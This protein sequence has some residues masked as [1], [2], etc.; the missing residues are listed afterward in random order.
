MFA[1][2][3]GLRNKTA[4]ARV[5]TVQRRAS[6][7]MREREVGNQA[8]LRRLE[9]Q[10]GSR[11]VIQPTLVVGRADEPLE[12]EAD[13]VADDVMQAQSPSF[14]LGAAPPRLSRKCAA[15]E[16]EER[17]LTK[18]AEVANSRTGGE[19]PAL[20]SDVLRSGGQPL[21]A[22]ARAFFEPR[23]ERDLSPVRIHTDADAAASA[24]LLGAHAYTV[25]SQI[26]FASG[27]YEP[28]TR[29]G[30]H[31]LAHELTHVVQQSG[32]TDTVLEVHRQTDDDATAMDTGSDVQAGG[33]TQSC[34]GWESDPQSFSIRAAQ[35]HARAI[36]NTSLSTPDSV[37]CSGKTCTVRFSGGAASP[38]WDISVD[39]SQVPGVVSVSGPA[40]P[41][42]TPFLTLINSCSYSYTCSTSGAISFK[43][44]SCT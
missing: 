21:D 11:A 42:G 14:S 20:V 7:S 24:R 29:G 33:Q 38:F 6:P 40:G 15:C 44:I 41:P 13:R 37:T 31:L 23:F 10:P 25:G 32:G 9:Q 28:G 36:M 34:A 27:Q 35:D 8:M 12:H 18:P 30:R 5:P 1:S 2:R 22:S 19:A 3:M 43:Q 26:V 17:L 16:E 39:L 4:V